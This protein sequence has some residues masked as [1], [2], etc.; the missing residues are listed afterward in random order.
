MWQCSMMFIPIL[1]GTAR[2]GRRSENAAKFV[3]KEAAKDGRFETQLID[4]RDFLVAAKTESAM[5]REKSKEWSEIMTRADGLIIVSPEYNHGYPG[6]LK[7]MLDELYDEYNR[8][9]VAICGCGAGLGGGRMVE[10]LRLVAIELKM[11]PVNSAVYFSNIKTL[12]DEN[13]NI[14]DPAAYSERLKKLFDELMWYTEALK[15]A[16]EKNEN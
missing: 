5:S 12:F 3:L 7:M 1:L 13:G 8:K 4:V 2:E 15:T 11:V 14:N 6:E 16:R 9:P 10:Q